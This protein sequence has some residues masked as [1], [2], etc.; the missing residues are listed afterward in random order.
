[1]FNW[2]VHDCLKILGLFVLG[3]IMESFG[4]TAKYYYADL[5]GNLSIH[6]VLHTE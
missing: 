3:T 5:N 2:D 6:K 1:M 4:L